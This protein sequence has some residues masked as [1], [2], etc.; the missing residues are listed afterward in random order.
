M[1]TYEL[2]PRLFKFC[3]FCPF[4]LYLHPTRVEILLFLFRH[5]FRHFSKR[6]EL[7]SKQ[8]IQTIF[9]TK[10]WTNNNYS[11]I[12]VRPWTPHPYRVTSP[13][14]KNLVIGLLKKRLEILTQNLLDI[15][16]WLR[17][18]LC[19]IWVERIRGHLTRVISP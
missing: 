15:V 8:Y 10:Y 18:Q 11:K 7:K 17:A 3:H 14:M 1:F 5:F 13:F 19:Y 9:A 12:T 2:T 6:R 16:P 4:L